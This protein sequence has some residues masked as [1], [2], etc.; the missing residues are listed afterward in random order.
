MPQFIYKKFLSPVDPVSGN[1][2]PAR[3]RSDGQTNAQQATYIEE[4]KKV[5]EELREARRAAL[6]LMEDAIAAKEALQKSEVKFRTLFESM[7]EGYILCEVIFD[8]NEKPVDILYLEANDAAVRM[9]GTELAGKTTRQLDP[10]FE[11]YWFD[12]WGRVA[13]TGMPERHEYCSGPLGVW[14][15][16]YVFKIGG[17]KDTKVAVVYEDITLQKHQQQRQEFLLKLSDALRAKSE[18][19]EVQETITHVTMDHFKSDRCYYCEIE[20]DQAIIRRDA[21]KEGF[22]SVAGVYSMNDIPI[23]K[24]IVEAGKYIIVNDVTTTAS[25][26]E[27]LRQL[28][29]QLQVISFIDVPVIKNDIIVGILCI[30]QSEPRNWTEFEIQLAEEVAQRTWTDI[31]R[32]KVEKTLRESEERKEFLLKLNDAIRQLNDPAEIQYE[33]ARLVAEQLNADRVHFA[34][35]TPDEQLVIRKE[36]VRGDAPSLAGKV[37]KPEVIAAVKLQVEEPVVIPDTQAFSLLSDEEKAALA[38][39]KIRSQ[40]SVALSRMGK[41]VATFSVDQTTPR[42]WKPLEISI[43]Q[44]AAERTWG[45]VERAKVEEALRQNEAL[46]AKELEDTRQLQKISS[47]MIEKGDLHALFDA[48]IDSAIDFMHSDSASIQILNAEGNQLL[49][50]AWKGFDPQSAEFWKNVAAGSTT[51]CGKALESKTRAV[52]PDVNA[53]KEVSKEDLKEYHRSGIVATQST[54]LISRSGKCVG[55]MSTHWKRVYEPSEREFRL[56][57]LLTRQVADLIERKQSEDALRHSEE[58]FRTLTN[59]VPQLIWTND[60]NGK[61]D[62]FNER[63][64]QY[65]GLNYE[66]SFGPGWEAIV[67]PDDAASVKKWNDALAKGD[68]F[69]TEYRLRA[70]DGSYCWFIGRNVPLKDDTGKI[71]GW[72]GSATDIER[73]KKAEESLRLS[74]ELNRIALL[75]AEMG[76]WDWDVVNGNIEGNEQYFQLLGVPEHGKKSFD[77]FLEF[78]HPGDR[79]RVQNELNHAVED[80]VYHSEFRIIRADTHKERWMNVYAR[81]VSNENKRTTRMVG[82]MYDITRRK[83]MEQQKDDFI[84]IASHEL[85]TPLTTIKVYVELLCEIF[86]EKNDTTG[87]TYMQKLDGQVDR[88]TE[89]VG[90][91]LDTAK[92]A[93]GQLKLDLQEFDMN[94][95]IERQI[96]DL[97][98]LSKAHKLVFKPGKL[99]K[100]TADK[101]RIGQVITNF[102]TNAVKYSPKGGEVLITSEEVQGGVKVSVHDIGI[103]IPEELQEKVFD[104]FFRINNP[105]VKTFPGMGIGLYIAQGIIR[106]H[107]GN[108]GVKSHSG[109]GSEFYF[110]VPYNSDSE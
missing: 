82:V 26:D 43:L 70:H 106:R 52:I 96:K 107:H 71:I 29:I 102:I 65:S 103:G 20:A 12:T 56:F 86:K 30:V 48:L 45:A 54:P 98:H 73:I 2:A 8:K 18:P 50:V 31:E 17:V 19:I 63:W 16:F 80:G 7:D 3:H 95:L 44:E 15:S 72:F 13:K 41:K 23:F 55:M 76:A 85:K 5:N 94:E 101:E 92:L 84:G 68:V 77:F 53:S 24:A 57:E 47:R 69:E 93:E 90:A 79:K 37:L 28:C 33:A 60:G 27:S 104:R 109:E 59:V 39:A 49:L 4:L 46:L 22:T 108:I 32:A 62:F 64:Y 40:L 81:A 110:F 100:V 97:K 35:I 38:E 74:E 105:D 58:R 6:N 66:E 75:S 99:E 9:T 88:I 11:Q 67:H 78:L 42:E 91:L 10:N 87:V 25:V 14:Y 21:A 83:K 61:A 1:Y 36:Y 51:T 89:L 34:E